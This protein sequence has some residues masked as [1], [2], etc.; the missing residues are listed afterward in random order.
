MEALSEKREIERGAAEL[1]AAQQEI[2]RL[3]GEIFD[4]TSTMDLVV[5]DLE[6]ASTVLSY[7]FA[8]YDFMDA[9]DP[10]AAL[11]FGE[12]TGDRSV[13]GEQSFK[14]FFGYRQITTFIDIVNDYISGSIKKLEA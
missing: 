9:P 2:N 5:L 3:K 4:K 8:E 13:H 14:W 7:W 1:A 12:Q 10:M 6:K 11:R